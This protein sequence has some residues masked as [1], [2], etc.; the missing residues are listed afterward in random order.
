ME[1]IYDWV[2][3]KLEK[4][5]KNNKRRSDCTRFFRSIEIS[6]L[7]QEKRTQFVCMDV[8]FVVVAVV[9]V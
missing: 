1:Q 4:G 9:C 5:K 3:I 7:V 8:V 2:T 6:V